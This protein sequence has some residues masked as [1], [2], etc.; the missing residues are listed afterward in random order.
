MEWVMVVGEMGWMII[1]ISYEM[2][3]ALGEDDNH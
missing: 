3:E 2:S 1:V